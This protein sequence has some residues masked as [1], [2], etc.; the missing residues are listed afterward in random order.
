MPAITI[1]PR[2]TSI[3]FILTRNNIGSINA[4]KKPTAEKQTNATDTL[5][6]FIEP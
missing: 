1:K 2:N 3:H 5:A 4:V 6:Y